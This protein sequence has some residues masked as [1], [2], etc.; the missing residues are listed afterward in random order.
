MFSSTQEL[1]R[2]TPKEFRLSDYKAPEYFT[3]HVDLSIDLTKKPL[4]VKSRLTVKPN[5][6]CKDR[7]SH[8]LLDGEKLKL[9]SISI[10]GSELE[11][12][13][14][15]MTD[16]ALLIFQIPKDKEFTI[17]SEV[18]IEESQ[19]L[20]GLYKTQGIYLVKA[21]TEGLRKVHFCQDRPDVLATYT[22]TIIADEKQYP[23]LLSNGEMKNSKSSDG[24]LTVT[25]EDNVPKPSYLFALVAGELQQIKDVFKRKSGKD[26]P[27][28]FY[29]K[30]AAA[31][32]CSFAMEVLKKAMSWEEK[33]YG[34]EC[35]LPRH[36]VA[37][38]DKYA[39]GASEPL[40]LNLFNTEYLLATPAMK[41]DDGFLTV[42]EV[43]SHEFFHYRSGDRATIRDW[44]NLVLKEGLTTF[45]EQ[46]FAEETF[47]QDLMRIRSV[48]YARRVAEDSKP[49][50]P[51]S[52]INVRNL[53]T[54]SA[55]EKGAEIFRMMRT[56]L[57]KEVFHQAIAK[58]F[59]DYDGKAATIEDLIQSLTKT[60]G[61]DLTQ[62][63]L[64]FTQ[65]GMPI[66][67]VKDEYNSE[68]QTY[69]LQVKQSSSDKN[70]KPLPIPLIIGLLDEKGQEMELQLKDAKDSSKEKT[71][72]ADKE[73]QEFQFTGL[74]SR[75]IPSL[76]RDFSAYVQLNYDYGDFNL[77]FLMVFD[78]NVFNR[79][80]AAQKCI[81]KIF[82]DSYSSRSLKSDS[83]EK[84]IA[85]SVNQIYFLDYI[86]TLR[87]LL[88][89]DSI[90]PWILSDL[91]TLPSERELASLISNPDLQAVHATREFILNK[92]ADQL[93]PDFKTKY[94]SL[95]K[96]IA[97]SIQKPLFK[98][99]DMR[100]AEKRALRN[101]CLKYLARSDKDNI[102]K[103][104]FALLQSSLQ[105]NMTDTITAIDILSNFDC[106]ERAKAL[107]LYYQQWEKDDNA[108][109]YW[110][111]VQA[112]SNSSSTVKNVREL[113]GH[114]AFDITNP[115]KV[116]A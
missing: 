31:D 82:I 75:P 91:L 85:T 13:D 58:F 27:I 102:V 14:Y 39:S 74:T 2:T 33:T 17:E 61:K 111:R 49:A 7:S 99:F 65:S 84:R 95:L 32:K 34:L 96:N 104:S 56:V 69:T 47:G 5:F 112:S 80:D 59:N 109:N 23:I 100:M 107:D 70:Y 18:E 46:E 72:I 64:W 25:W 83:K 41:N 81:A 90:N 79:W 26:L 94:D 42:A 73:Y 22:T 68:T 36:M 54:A 113:L 3:T 62:F 48:K 53:Y 89:D 114:K 93:A 40:G 115:N 57:G 29:V 1:K 87:I 92:I 71:L 8:F 16:K 67:E 30:K 106:P 97:E 19:D 21:E 43:V 38:I 77:P 10:N 110:F 4:I 78:S 44:Y 86:K 66:L 103:K 101:T 63:L 37:G 60:T 12:E 50:R 108:I 45:R 51:D 11:D 24:I 28:E 6:E 105:T 55:Y 35:E 116:Y 76:L 98:D 88:K 15:F 52:Y 20:F 9:K